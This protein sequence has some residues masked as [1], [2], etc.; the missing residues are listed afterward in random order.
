MVFHLF[1][2]KYPG[3]KHAAFNAF[4]AMDAN[5]RISDRH[6]FRMDHQ[7]LPIKKLYDLQIMA[8]TRAAAAEC[9]NLMV[10]HV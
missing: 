2:P 9:K 10:G 6:I 8:T 5:L 4:P 7:V 3:T 1:T